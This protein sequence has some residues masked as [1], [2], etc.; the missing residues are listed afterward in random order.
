MTLSTP[1]RLPRVL[2][3][4][5]DVSI[6]QFVSMALEDE[7]LQL[8]SCPTLKAAR[9]A[10]ELA[11]TEMALVLLDMMLPDGS[12]ME[13]LQDP[14]RQRAG[15]TA[16]W[17]VFSAGIPPETRQLL[18]TLDVT[19]VLDK[20]V[21]LDRLLACVRA[22]CTS[23]LA[24]QDRPL[25][26]GAGPT[27]PQQPA[28]QAPSEPHAAA[29]LIRATGHSLAHEA[30]AIQ[31]YFFGQEALF[32]AMKHQALRHLPIDIQTIERSIADQDSQQL[33]RAAH[34]LKSVTRMLGQARAAD[35]AR[36]LED[37]AA[38]ADTPVWQGLWN[39]LRAELELWQ[40]EARDS[41]EPPPH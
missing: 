6:R 18:A 34:N 32:R 29:P 11:G 37:A 41:A 38:H 12:G 9:Q 4:E 3:V 17:V 31:H 36:A 30:E 1:Q 5:D 23:W 16:R 28:L 14:Q 15:M 40:V 21:P 39:G 26:D 33:R 10:L 24:K 22:A 27:A 19:Q 35:L 8:L 7:P 2:L 13:L 25:A 20:P